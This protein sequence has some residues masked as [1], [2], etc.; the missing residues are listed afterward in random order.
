MIILMPS[1]RQFVAGYPQ[2]VVVATTYDTLSPAAPRFCAL[3]PPLPA[4]GWLHPAA[5]AVALHWQIPAAA[6]VRL[7]QLHQL[8]L[9][10]VSAVAVVAAAVQFA[11][12]VQGPAAPGMHLS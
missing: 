3:L 4:A 11:A 8:Q 2:Q 7:L 10:H 1:M 6:A 5:A 12:A 9:L